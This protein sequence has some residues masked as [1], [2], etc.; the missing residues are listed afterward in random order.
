MH[1]HDIEL[2]LALA[3]GSLE[4][5]QIL[6]G[7]RLGT[8]SGSLVPV[9]CGSAFKNKGVQPLLNAVIDYLPGP[10]D[11][12]AY[13]EAL[14]TFTKRQRRFGRTGEQ[15]RDHRGHGDPTVG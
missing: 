12:E 2:I 13:R 15:A 9:L 14:A 4:E 7:L 1:S 5:R 3:D 10:L 8:V 6:E 11:V